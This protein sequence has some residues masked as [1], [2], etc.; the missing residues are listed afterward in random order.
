MSE[1]CIC[2]EI[3]GGVHE[4]GVGRRGLTSTAYS[5]FGVADDSVLH[6]DQA[7]LKQRREGEN[8]RGGVAAGVG[9]QTC[10]PDL[11]PVKLRA[12]VDSFCLQSGGV[13]RVCILQM[14]D[15]SIGIVF[16]AP[17]AAEVDDFDALLDCFGYPFTRLLMRCSKKQH[18]DP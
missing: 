14:V 9:N 7:S 1:D 16:Q 4:V 3:V 11:V 5:R 10:L 18:F 17:C 8:D 13:L 12:S 2:R 15:S 6:V